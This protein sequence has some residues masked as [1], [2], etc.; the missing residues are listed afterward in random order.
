[1]PT[2]AESRAP[3]A[4]HE[5][6]EHCLRTF[7]EDFRPEWKAGFAAGLRFVV[8]VFLD[9]DDDY[10]T[11]NLL[12]SPNSYDWL[13]GDAWE[14]HG[15]RVVLDHLAKVTG[16]TRGAGSDDLVPEPAPDED[17]PEG[18]PGA[19]LIGMGFAA[20]EYRPRHNTDCPDYDEGDEEI[21]DSFYVA[22]TSGDCYVRRY[23]GLDRAVTLRA[24]VDLHDMDKESLDAQARAGAFAEAHLDLF[25]LLNAI[26]CTPEAAR[27]IYGTPDP[28]N[29]GALKWMLAN[30]VTAYHPN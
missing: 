28:H 29:P 15:P 18:Y 19:R 13:P 7:D 20:P 27:K 25:D 11:G 5:A 2:H 8:P 30:N 6:V 24:Y 12:F 16:Q 23:M 4:W 17:S 22:F 9:A 10:S 14:Q 1:M 26:L 21:S 3:E